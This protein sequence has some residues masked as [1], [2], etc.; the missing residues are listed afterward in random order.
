MKELLEET[1]SRIRDENTLRP[2]MLINKVTQTR[3]PGCKSC[4]P[5]ASHVK[6]L[7]GCV[8]NLLNAQSATTATPPNGHQRLS[9][10]PRQRCRPR[11]SR[12]T[13]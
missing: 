12:S 4:E 13:L 11:F 8:S 5:N 3:R 6:R 1:G 2:L 9:R 10:G 7:A